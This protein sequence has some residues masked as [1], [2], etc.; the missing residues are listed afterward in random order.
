LK[1][2]PAQSKA[3]KLHFRNEVRCGPDA[4]AGYQNKNATPMGAAFFDRDQ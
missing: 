4:I 3:A 2:T 1:T